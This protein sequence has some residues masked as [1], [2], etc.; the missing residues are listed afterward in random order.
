[1]FLRGLPNLCAK[2]KRPPKVK[3]ADAAARNSFGADLGTPDFYRISKIAPL[4][5]ATPYLPDN[6][7]PI[8]TTLPQKF[9]DE[10]GSFVGSKNPSL[11]AWIV[12][13][14]IA[15]TDMVI[16]ASG[17]AHMPLVDWSSPSDTWEENDKDDPLVRR[18][19]A[20]Y[21]LE[22][23][24]ESAA[25]SSQPQEPREQLSEADMAYL[26][27]QNRILLTN[28]KQVERWPIKHYLHTPSGSQSP[29]ATQI[30]SQ[31][32]GICCTGFEAR[33]GFS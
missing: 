7:F 2:M 3:S 11:N 33:P 12:E 29:G 23:T 28:A 1:M 24:G 13:D 9:G 21:A 10:D 18:Q 17:G 15:A 31:L 32:F 16:G 8:A 14:S 30:H 4:P 5:P 19:Q 27:H 20:Q 26:A 25:P 22:D 6:G